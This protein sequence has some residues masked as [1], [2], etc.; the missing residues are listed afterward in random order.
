MGLGL[1]VHPGPSGSGCEWY[2]CKRA[3]VT[4]QE[5]K[6]VHQHR[7]QRVGVRSEILRNVG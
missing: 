1:R 3:Y 6:A 4:L 7:G 5:V 2:A